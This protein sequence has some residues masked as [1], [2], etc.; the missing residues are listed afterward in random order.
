MLRKLQNG[1]A[2]GIFLELTDLFVESTPKLL[3]QACSSLDNPTQLAIIAHTIK[4]SCS[5][6]GADPMEAL[7][8]ELEQLG[9][10]GT[11]QGAREI[12][13]AIEVEFFNVRAAL[14]SHCAGA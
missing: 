2:P 1:G 4:G 8:L 13:N 5:I 7:C 11:S 3:S 9:R 10:K 12:I 14:A 6:F